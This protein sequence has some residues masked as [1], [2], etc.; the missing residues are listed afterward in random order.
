MNIGIIILSRFSS[1]RFPGKALYEINGKAL[2]DHLTDNFNLILPN[3][4]C[5]VATSIEKSDDVIMS[6][7]KSKNIEC[8]RGSL[9][10]VSERVLKCSLRY[11]WDYF[12]RINGDNLFNDPNI[13]GNII[14]EIDITDFDFISNVEGRTFPYGMSVEI[15]KTKF[16]KD[17][18]K[19]FTNKYHKEHVTSWLYDNQNIGKRFYFKNFNYIYLK[20]I[21]LSID[22]FKDIELAEKIFN[23]YNGKNHIPINVLNQFFRLNKKQK[24]VE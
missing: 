23:Y 12:V 15:I 11:K 22:E 1:S 6:H 2:I 5:V 16:Y 3:I 4:K 8:F 17:V 21:K 18:F 19:K 24:Q 14:N 13:L 10:N 7:C 9:L 20:G